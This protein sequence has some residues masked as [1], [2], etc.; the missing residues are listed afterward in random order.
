M[1]V[2]LPHWFTGALFVA[3]GARHGWQQP[4]SSHFTQSSAVLSLHVC[5][6]A[7]LGWASPPSFHPPLLPQGG[8]AI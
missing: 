6:V 4:A 1:L 8:A 2:C 3:C 7:P 5:C